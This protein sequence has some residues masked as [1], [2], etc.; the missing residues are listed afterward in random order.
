MF[1][2][3]S[4][5]P[6]LAQ[7]NQFSFHNTEHVEEDQQL[8]FLHIPLASIPGQIH[9]AQEMKGGR[10]LDLSVGRSQV[11]YHLLGFSCHISS[12][13]APYTL[14]IVKPIQKKPSP[15]RAALGQSR[16]L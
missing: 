9:L 8:A 14:T 2:G 6:E 3:E 12:F 5:W 7:R 1:Y 10:K 13:V 16:L 15:P 4:C 11:S